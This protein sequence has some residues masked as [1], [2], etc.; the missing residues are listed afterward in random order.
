M[1]GDGSEQPGWPC[2]PNPE[3][4]QSGRRPSSCGA[5]GLQGQLSEASVQQCPLSHQHN[6]ASPLL[7]RAAA[8][9][10]MKL[11]RHQLPGL[12]EKT[13][14]KINVFKDFSLLH[15]AK[16]SVNIIISVI[17]ELLTGLNWVGNIGDI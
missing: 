8:T 5:A 9:L 17:P 10:S 4:P 11:G 7:L 15:N 12:L 14:K 6:S 13:K 2:K 16:F 3:S 1:K